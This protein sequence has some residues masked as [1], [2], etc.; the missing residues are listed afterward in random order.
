M[1]WQKFLESAVDVSKLTPA[2]TA[3][4]SA[5]TF[6]ALSSVLYLV[7]KMLLGVGRNRLPSTEAIGSKRPLALGALTEA[8]AMAIPSSKKQQDKLRL[9]L[10][11]AGFYHRRAVEEFLGV[12]NAALIGWL[13]F[14]GT[15]MVALA[16]PEEDLT[17]KVLLGGGIMLIFIYGLPRVILSG[18]AVNRCRR[19]QHALPDALDMINMTVTGGLPLRDAIQRVARELHRIHPDIACELRMVEMQTETGSLDLALRQFAKRL[20]IPDVTALASMVQHAERLGGQVTLAFREFADSIRKTRRQQAEERGN[21]ASIKLLFP[22]V[23]FLAPPI[24]ILLLGPAV[25]EM[26]NFLTRQQAPGGALSQQPGQAI[27]AAAQPNR[28]PTPATGDLPGGAAPNLPSVL[29]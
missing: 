10:Q 28:G 3:M 4:I 18:Q 11:Q 17:P 1:D 21:K 7:G 13:L 27:R 14:V 15:A 29:R 19:I 9:E 23:F 12:R 24:Y 20:D 25:I 5:G 22:I 16:S 8:L 6:V 2:Q 26:K